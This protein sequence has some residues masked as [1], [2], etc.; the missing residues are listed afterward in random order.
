MEVS[1]SLRVFGGAA[2]RITGAVL[3][4]EDSWIVVLRPDEVQDLSE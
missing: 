1:D 4:D 3:S 2:C